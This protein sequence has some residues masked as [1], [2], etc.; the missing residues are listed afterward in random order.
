[1]TGVQTCALPICWSIEQGT[2][3]EGPV[4]GWRKYFDADNYLPDEYL[5]S[6]KSILFPIIRGIQIKA[7]VYIIGA[8]ATE[9]D[10][11][12]PYTY[13]TFAVADDTALGGESDWQEGSHPDGKSWWYEDAIDNSLGLNN[14][15]FSYDDVDVLNANIVGYGLDVL[16]S[17][18]NLSR[19]V[20]GA[21]KPVNAKV[22]AAFAAKKAALKK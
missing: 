18:D 16:W 17:T 5:E 14:G 3:G 20:K 2:A 4:D 22:R 6:P 12:Y 13:I 21:K 9:W 8:P 11:E 1:M 19:K 15:D 7:E 10:G